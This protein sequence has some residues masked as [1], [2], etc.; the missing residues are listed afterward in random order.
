MKS[1]EKLH[2][3]VRRYRLFDENNLYEEIARPFCQ[4]VV[5]GINMDTH[6]KTLKCKQHQNGPAFVLYQHRVQTVRIFDGVSEEPKIVKC[7]NYTYGPDES[8]IVD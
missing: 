2:E 1:K 8:D 4:P 3:S 7:D 5:S 6:R